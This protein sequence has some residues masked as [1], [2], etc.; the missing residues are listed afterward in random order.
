M[1]ATRSTSTHPDASITHFPDFSNIKNPLCPPAFSITI[2]INFASSLSRTISPAKV[3]DALTTVVKS[4]TAA[5]PLVV[6]A[7]LVDL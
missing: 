7:L 6:E 4:S 1:T 2:F 5:L 3:C